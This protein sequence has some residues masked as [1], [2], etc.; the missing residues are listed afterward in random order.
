MH[1]TGMLEDGKVFDSSVDRAPFEF[2]LGNGQVIKGWD[3]GQYP[4]TIVLPV[5]GW[6]C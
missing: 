6:V 5:L 3:E 2:M 4:R 1:Y